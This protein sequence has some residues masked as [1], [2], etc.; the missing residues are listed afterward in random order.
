MTRYWLMR[1]HYLTI[2]RQR[3]GDY[4][5]HSPRRNRGEYS[6]IITEP[7]ANDCFSIFT[8]VFCVF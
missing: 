6:P 5:E 3:R 1:V 8:Q 2:I 4:R 7:E